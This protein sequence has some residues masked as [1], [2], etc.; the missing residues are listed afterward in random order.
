MNRPPGPHSARLALSPL[1][2]QAAE[3]ALRTSPGSLRQDAP[4]RALP[5][6][7]CGASRPRRALPPI[8]CSWLH[9]CRAL[10]CFSCTPPCTSPDFLQE[11]LFVQEKRGSARQKARRTPVSACTSP[12]FLQAAVHFACFLARVRAVARI[13]GKCTPPC[14]N[15]GE[16]HGRAGEFEPALY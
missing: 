1:F 15:R 14:R 4:R 9:L 11:P 10:P 13:R 7:S 16:V 6:F 2:M 3:S 5:C 8:P 12:I